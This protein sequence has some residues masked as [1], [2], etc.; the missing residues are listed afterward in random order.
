MRFAG[1][2]DV[3]GSQDLVGDVKDFLRRPLRDHVTFDPP[4]YIAATVFGSGQPQR[5]AADERD[6]FGLDLS[7]VPRRRLRITHRVLCS[8]TVEDV[9]ALVEGGLVRHRIDRAD[10]DLSL[11][12]VAH[13][14]AVQVLERHFADGERRERLRPVP[15]GS[16]QYLDWLTF[17]LAEREPVGPVGEPDENRVVFAPLLGL[18]LARQ[19][20]TE[21]DGTLAAFD[22]SAFR[23]PAR[24]GRDRARLQPSHLAL[25][26]S[27]HLIS[28]GIPV[29]RLVRLRDHTG[30]S[31]GFGQ[32]FGPPGR[33]VVVRF[34]SHRI[35]SFMM[36]G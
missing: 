28:D 29:K 5:F 31:H 8:V 21:H 15:F 18:A 2:R 13:T 35:H 33:V 22:L 19:R 27:E 23:L 7:Q 11:P 34:M 10:G 26:Q 9:S 4:L 6:R 14:V 17:R 25:Q 30:L 24:I 12:G 20:H 16:R 36:A 3:P 1:G 32:E